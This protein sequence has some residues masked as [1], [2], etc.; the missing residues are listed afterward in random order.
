MKVISPVIVTD[1]MVL[2][3][4]V[5]EPTLTAEGDGTATVAWSNATTYPEGA[6]VYVASTHRTYRSAAAG[7]LNNDPLTTQYSTPPKWVD[8]GSTNKWRMLRADANFQTVGASPLAVQIAPGQRVSALA[9]TGI[10]ADQ[11]DIEMRDGSNV[12]VYTYS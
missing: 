12:V 3:D 11:V 1:A 7:N 8:I 6:V 10:V 9:V 4:S 2:A 5:A